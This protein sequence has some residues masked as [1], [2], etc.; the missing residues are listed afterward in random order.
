MQNVSL[1]KW[2]KLGIASLVFILWVIWV[3]NFWLLL[4]YPLVFDNYITKKI[5][6]DFWKKTKDGKKPNAII[7]WADALIFA[8]FAVYMINIFL[9]Q[10]Y[11]IPTSS[12]E[13]SLLV[14]DHLFVSKVSYG[15]R[16]PN[17]PIA[18]P[19]VQ[20]T[21]PIT[22]SKSYTSWPHWDYKRL[23]GFGDVKR[24]DI[25][26]FNFP[27]GDTVPFK[28]T[29]PDYYNLMMETGKS[30][31][32]RDRSLMP[33]QAFES[34]WHRNQ[35][36]MNIGRQVINNDPNTFGEVLYRPVDRRDNYV[37]RCVA[38]PG[39]EF[40]IRSNQIYINGE[41]VTNP[42]DIQHNYQIQTDGTVL[43]DRFF[44]R[45]G[46]SKEDQQ[47]IPPNY[48][49]PLNKEKAEKVKAMSFIKSIE[50][51]EE[52][53]NGSG[54]Q[55]FPFS[56]DYDWSRDNFGPLK[57]PKAGE[58][59]ELTMKNIVLYDRII[60]NFE[61]NKLEVKNGAIYINGEIANSYTFE[62]D[63][64]FMLG[65]NRHKSA[66][67]RYWGFVPEDHIVG[68]PI[69]VW[70]SLDKDKGFPANIRWKRFFKIVHN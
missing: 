12:L 23:K 68:K 9:F 14:G 24:D 48:Y 34:D 18:F 7:E 49:L 59:V 8:L 29:N 65:D 39:D 58:S 28:V 67:S 69:L 54:F 35:F 16:M 40:E 61:G 17:T 70:L 64:Y 13:K 41:A 37:K 27:A 11:K 33:Q 46:I 3:A 30:Q 22:N 53:P 47:G 20:N 6:W 38:I 10:N 25:V 1:F 63:Y 45:L 52:K 36:L 60:Q 32:M 51:E 19:L 66:D 26:V 21:F 42:E 15:P 5:P 44:E 43:N 31:I 62:M 50:I 56:S 57:M 2:I 55:S 4:L